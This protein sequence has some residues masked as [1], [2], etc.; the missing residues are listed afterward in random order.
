MTDLASHKSLD[1]R[2]RRY[3]LA[4]LLGWTIILSVILARDLHYSDQMVKLLARNKANVHFEWIVAFRSWV[5]S[6]QG[7]YAP[8]S[9]RTPP[10]EYLEVKERDITTPF[11]KN[12]TL[13]NP[14][15]M[16][17]QIFE[18]YSRQLD[19]H[20][21]ITSL[22]PIR[23]A[24][25]PDEW[26]RA[27]LESFERNV[28]ETMEFTNIGDKPYL[29]LMRPLFINEVCL[30]CHAKQGYHMGD[31]RGGI[32]VSV[33]I[34]ELLLR[35]ESEFFTKIV[36][37][38]LLW[39]LGI[40]V[41]RYGAWRL[42][43][44]ILLR[45]KAESEARRL[46]TAMRNAADMILITDTDGAIQYVNPTFERI[47]GFDREEVIGQN[48]RILKSGKHE[49]EFFEHMWS[50]ILGGAVWEGHI[51]NKRKDGTEY[52]VE[53]TISP[54]S[55][56]ESGITGFVAIKRDISREAILTKAREFFA[57]AT[58]HELRTPLTK[59][60]LFRILFL[61]LVDDLPK[62]E[63]ITQSSNVLDEIYADI[64]RVVTATSILSGLTSLGKTASGWV[65][66]VM[67]VSHCVDTAE[68]A[69]KGERRKVKIIKELSGMEA[70][71]LVRGD[72]IMIQ[73]VLE[74]IL[75]NAIK[76]TPDGKNTNV[77]CRTEGAKAIVE[78][79]D[80]GVG[81]QIEN[82]EALFAP[83]FSLEEVNEHSSG[84]YTFKGGGLGL[85]LT[86]ARMIMDQHKGSIEIE[87]EGEKKGTKVTLT[88]PVTPL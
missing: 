40:G 78:I 41:I 24:N 4:L 1:A 8:I 77:T 28:P 18:E 20:G 17:R 34:G 85:G 22:R 62:S 13:I 44:Q 72:Q 64:Q 88:F 47:S 25:S 87:S 30:K 33:P 50:T 60:E 5:A 74:E 48:P 53:A 29:R 26:E 67:V 54:V 63:R 65:N 12:L 71:T 45:G 11:G 56:P 23:P 43:D 7:V 84:Q 21:H 15:Y 75:S 52:E 32:S 3:V 46:A 70:D 2:Y 31:V 42:S 83:F 16:T 80:P 76:Y 86:I 61:D 27:A 55:E 66:L 57:S 39:I 51:T 35:K 58:S 38:G 82:T 68:I 73:R 69:A 10:N 81:F 79:T 19:V 49:P 36:T 59:L 9:E 14:A 37:Y 6:H